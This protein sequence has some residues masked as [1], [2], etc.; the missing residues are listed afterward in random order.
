MSQSHLSRVCFVLVLIDVGFIRYIYILSD[1][2][3][4]NS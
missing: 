1:L 4:P 3:N 2:C